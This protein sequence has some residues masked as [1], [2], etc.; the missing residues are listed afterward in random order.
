M[1]LLL[2]ETDVR[3]LLDM[4]LAMELVETAFRRLADHTGISQ[5]RRRVKLGEKG[6]M[7]YMAAS[8][9]AGGYAGLKI[10]TVAKGKARYIMPL[11]QV[12]TGDLMALIE[13]DYLGQM[14]TGAATGVGT[15]FMARSDACVA[16]MI[17]TGL[18]ARTHLEAICQARQFDEI[19][20]FGLDPARRE[21][22]ASEMSAKLSIR[23]TP[24]SSGEEAVRGADV[25]TTCTSSVTPVAEAKWFKR[26]VHIN[27][28]GVNFAHKR[29]LD[30]DTVKLCDI[31]AV[32]SVEQ[33]KIES[34]ELIAAFGDDSAQWSR[35]SELA[36]IV[37]GKVVGRTSP[38][39]I[40]LF[41]SN[42][43]AIEDIGVAGRILE[44]AQKQGI[45][46]EVEMWKQ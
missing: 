12:G 42:G 19:R 22:F 39:Q 46:R 1:A 43:I 13:A 44:M 14:R 11:F 20:V 3:S 35:V 38:G 2:T 41:K 37:S 21:Q 6:L 4:R 26:G 18:Q 33:T 10:Y 36:D 16:G 31:V 28:T 8:D 30:A 7:N 45:G 27:A 40:T 9:Q 15:K 34:G 29:E 23:V 17:G 5:P 25:V 24:V 32:D